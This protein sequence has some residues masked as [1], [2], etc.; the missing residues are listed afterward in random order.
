MKIY[1]NYMEENSLVSILSHFFLLYIAHITPLDDRMHLIDNIYYK[2]IF[3]VL[4]LIR[5][6]ILYAPRQQYSE[7]I[8]EISIYLTGVWW[9]FLLFYELYYSTTF[10]MIDTVLLFE[11]IGITSGGTFS[12]FKKKRI[13]ITYILI[14]MLP[15]L[16]SMY[17][18]NTELGILL[19]GAMVLFMSFNLVYSIK[20]NTIWSEFK[21][22]Q[23]EVLLQSKELQS[24]NKDLNRALQESEEA[25]KIKSEFLA[26]MSHEIRT[27]MNGVIGAADIL[28]G[29]QLDVEEKKLVDI[30]YK[31][32]NSLMTIINDILDFSKIEAGKMEIENT[33]FNLLQS[34][35]N[36]IEIFKHN[37]ANKNLELIFYFTPKIKKEVIGDEIRI[38]QIL[39]NLLGNAIKFTKKGQVFLKV[40]IEEETETDYTLRFSIEDTGIGIPKDKQHKIFESFTQANGSV[41]RNFGGT[42]LGTTISKMLVELMGGQIALESPNPNNT[43]ND[44]G[45]IF[46]FILKLKKS[47]TLQKRIIVHKDIAGKKALI[48]DDNKTNCFVLNTMLSNWS[49]ETK[50]VYN[51]LS[52]SCLIDESNDFDIIFIDYNM[53]D[54]NGFY[55]FEKIKNKLR[56]GTKCI[57]ISSNSADITVQKAKRLGFDNL[58]HKPIKQLDLY[59]IILNLFAEELPVEPSEELKEKQYQFNNL[60]VLIAEDNII[61]QKI[62]ISALKQ[63]GIIPEI[64]NNGQEVLDKLEHSTYDVIFMDIQMPVLD[65]IETVKRMRKNSNNTLVVAMTANAMKG[66]RE[67]CLD[68]GMNDYISKPFKKKDLYELLQKVH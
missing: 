61:N 23:E 12:M 34:I 31:S 22:S 24:Y 35:E 54:Q 18:S 58:L 32:G 19:S 3:I 20:H 16:I 67:M 25:A 49:I 6:Y 2:G 66:D 57:M 47:K 9:S 33:S 50:E 65:G 37:A 29:M 17:F 63:V 4:L 44:K 42:G 48:I 15:T 46:Y 40:D 38:N 68:A 13:V 26:N 60:R 5:F 36:T 43:L 21:K 10:D 27:P 1:Q 7:T 41:T 45:S 59:N 52:A 11:I 62:A 56:L 64:A 39:I 8:A 55:V 28:R 53:P 14:L 30:I 51:G